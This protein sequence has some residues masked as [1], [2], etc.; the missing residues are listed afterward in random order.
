MQPQMPAKLTV[1]RQ[2]GEGRACHA[3]WVQSI[4]TVSENFP[5]NQVPRDYSICSLAPAVM[6]A[7]QAGA[8]RCL[9]SQV[10]GIVGASYPRFA[11]IWF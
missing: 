4:L 8:G 3:F 2:Q 1:L 9:E 6:P 7:P 11:E 5:S 10:L